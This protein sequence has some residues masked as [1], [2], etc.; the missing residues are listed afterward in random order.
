MHYDS[1]NPLDFP[2]EA[3]RRPPPIFLWYNGPSSSIGSYT[4]N[5]RR[6]SGRR[7][8]QGSMTDMDVGGRCG[9]LHMVDDSDSGEGETC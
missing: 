4:I 7:E 9:A 3:K 6:G 1:R 5:V 8:A 2:I